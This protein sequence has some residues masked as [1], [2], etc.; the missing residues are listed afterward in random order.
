[1]A[2]ETCRACGGEGMDM[3]Y[4]SGPCPECGRDG[5]VWRPDRPDD[6]PDDRP[7]VPDTD[8]DTP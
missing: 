2:W 7:E 8:E 4:G 5:I 1:M 6:R 3:V